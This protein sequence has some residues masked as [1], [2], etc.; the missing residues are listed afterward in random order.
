[1]YVCCVGRMSHGRNS[2]V[3]C[4]MAKCVCALEREEILEHLYEIQQHDARG[5]L[6]VVLSTLEKEDLR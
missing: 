5:W 4:H 6:S 2:L 3:D 1:M